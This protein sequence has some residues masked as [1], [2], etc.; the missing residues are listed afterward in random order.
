MKVLTGEQYTL[1]RLVGIKSEMWAIHT[2]KELPI[3]DTQFGQGCIIENNTTGAAGLLL[4][5][6]VA[7][8]DLLPEPHMSRLVDVVDGDGWINI[9]D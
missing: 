7:Y 6:T 2:G 4:N 8:F 1:P 3:T 9:A 5:E